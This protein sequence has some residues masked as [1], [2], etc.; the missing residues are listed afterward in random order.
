MESGARILVVD[1]EESVRTSVGMVLTFHGFVVAS[2]SGVDEARD[3]LANETFDV[4][5]TDLRMSG[6][7]D[8]LLVIEAARKRYPHAVVLLM[9]A[10][11]N[12]TE[13]ST[14]LTLRSDEIISKPADV[15]T[16]LRSI[17]EKL[18][19]CA[20]PL[21]TTAAAHAALEQVTTSA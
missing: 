17:H 8:G 7:E 2:A 21:V 14:R 10:Y 12:F 3:K 6:P 18:A 19:A 11:A 15:A 20:A 5:L 4:V 9:S 16:L 1:D 13:T